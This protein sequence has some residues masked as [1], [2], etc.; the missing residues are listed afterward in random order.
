MAQQEPYK[1]PVAALRCFQ[2]IDTTTAMTIVAE[3]HDFRR[4][5][6]PRELM[7]YLGLVP[8]E[9]SSSE[10]RR[11][12]S[13]TKAGNSHVRRLLIE[14][15]WHYRHPPRLGPKLI[16]RRQGQSTAVIAIADKAAQRLYRRFTRLQARGKPLPKVAV[17]IAR[18]LVGF[19]WSV[20]YPASSKLA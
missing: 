14:S 11:L 3:L 19:V 1:E 13:I 9:H 8:S 6:S 5:Q 17:A 4:F 2:G 16:L 18:E 20:V 12:G 7:A 10:R 15:A